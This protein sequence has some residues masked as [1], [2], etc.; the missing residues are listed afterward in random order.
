MKLNKTWLWFIDSFKEKCSAKT[1]VKYVNR[2]AFLLCRYRYI[3]LGFYYVATETYCGG[4]EL[5]YQGL[6]LKVNALSCST[7]NPTL[8]QPDSVNKY[9]TDIKTYLLMQSYHFSVLICRFELLCRTVTTRDLKRSSSPPKYV[10]VLR[11]LP[12]QTYWLWKSIDTRLYMCD[13][14]IQKHQFS[15]LPAY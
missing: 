3:L 1:Q 4:S 7:P 8:N 12:K 15:N 11:E 6:Y 13:A 10:S 9:K 2:G 5:K 14:N